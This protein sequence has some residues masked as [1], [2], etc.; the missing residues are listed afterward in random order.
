V[1]PASSTRNVPRSVVAVFRVVPAAE[2]A[3]VVVDVA[4]VVV[5]AEPLAEVVGADALVVADEPVACV[6]VVA[7]V[8]PLHAAATNANT[9]K[10][11][12]P[13]RISA[14]S[15]VTYQYE[16]ASHLRRAWFS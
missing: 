8:A 3:A 6:A 13:L 7:A 14:P 9:M 12:M 4:V 16:R 1:L 2:A 15:I 10:M 5:G 11:N